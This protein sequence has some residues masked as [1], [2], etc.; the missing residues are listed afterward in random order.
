MPEPR[1]HIVVDGDVLDAEVFSLLSR[2]EI[3]ESDMDPSVCA[4]RFNLRQRGSGEFAPIDDGVFAESTPI[5]VDLAA[6]GGNLIRL[7]SGFITHVRPHFESIASNCYLELLAQ[8][9]AAILGAHERV[10][11]YPDVTDSDAFLEV[12]K[13]YD[14]FT[15]MADAT[16]ARNDASEHL[17][18]QRGSDWQFITMLARRNGFRCYFEHDETT[19][20]DCCYFVKPALDDPAQA[21]LT[22]LREGANLAWL[23]L[24]HVM[25]GPVR[26]VGVGVDP[27]RK[28]LVEG[29]GRRSWEPMGE[30]LAVDAVESGLQDAGAGGGDALLRDPAPVDAVLAAASSAASDADAM[31]VEARGELD[32]AL[33][34]GLLRARRPVLIKGVGRVYT[35]AYWV[36]AVRT[37]MAGG[38]LSQ[39][40]IAERNAV[41]LTGK[42]EFGQSAEEVPPE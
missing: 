32:P 34:R 1:V 15:G 6:P 20:K 31:V 8:D 2:L 24:Q 42:E 26:H 38:I 5:G 41:G 12:M 18:V 7:F 27:I 29:D 39:T 23:D 21:D 9:G 16:N 30:S 13:R 19:G 37:T 28:A 10:A 22:I 25:T 3:R 40:F 11:T 17:L 14:S 33:Y 36:R 4:L 35:G